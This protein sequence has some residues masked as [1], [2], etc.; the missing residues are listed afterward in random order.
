MRNGHDSIRAPVQACNACTGAPPSGH[1]ASH[2]PA[3][4]TS[5]PMKTDT[6]PV[7]AART[8]HG[9][10]ILSSV[11]VTQA[12]TAG[13][14]TYSFG[15]YQLPVAEEFGVS[16]ST[17]AWGLSGI[18]LMGAVV[19]PLMGRA[20][21]RRSNRALRLGAGAFMASC[22]LAMTVAPRLWLIG[23]LFVF[24]SSVGMAG[25][26]PQ[27]AG[28]LAATWFSRLR[29][30]ALG[31]SSVGTSAGGLAV[32]PLVAAAI[33]AWGWRGAAVVGAVLLG[34][35]ALPTVALSIRNRPADLGLYPDG[36]AQPPPAPPGGAAGGWAFGRL[37]RERNFWVIA[38]VIGT[39]FG[40]VSGIISNLPPLVAEFGVESQQ[41]A[42]L[43]SLLSLAGIAGKLCFGAVADRLDKRLLVWSGMSMLVG[44]LMIASSDPSLTVLVA[45]TGAMG[46]ALGGALPLWGAL[47]GDCFGPEAFGE[48]MGWMGP[49][50]LP[51][52][53]VGIQLLPWCYEHFGSYVPGLRICIGAILG[54]AL[55]LLLLRLPERRRN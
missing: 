43:L 35:V 12:V 11:F 39:I 29:G 17:V 33:A 44:F 3:P 13:L 40:T 37:A 52:N 1:W 18:M 54:A 23:L 50:M 4:H 22:L 41:A 7:A 15:L 6:H 27:A 14:T 38:L 45:A 31:I 21:D 47:I 28:K 2:A 25:L 5:T 19:A 20:L 42:A 48:V 32:P 36:D 9:W 55:L 51:F 24:G 8:F 53:I 46:F 49:V 16:R 34:V 10:W 26:G 30:R